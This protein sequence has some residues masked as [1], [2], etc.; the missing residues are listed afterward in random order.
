[1]AYARWRHILME[2]Q[3]HALKA[4]DEWNCTTGNY[5]DFLTH[6]HKAWHYLLHAEFHKA[7]IDYHYS[8][9]KT[10]HHQLIDGEPKAWDLDRCLRERF[11]DNKDPVRLNGELFVAL[12]NKV[13]H[14]YEHNLKIVTGGRAQALVVNYEQEMVAHFGPECSLADRLRFPISL[15][16]LTAEGREQ[17][18]AAAKKLPKHTRDLVAKFEA[19]IDPA[20]L[21]DLR[22]DYR[23]RLVPIIGSKTDADLAINFVKLDE[24]SES[25]RRTMVE[26]GRLGTVIE[27][28]KHVEVADK[29]KLLPGRVARLVE[30]QVP[31]EFSVHNEHAKMWRRLGVRPATG[32]SDPHATNAK[33]CIYSEAFGAYVYTRAWVKKVVREIGTVEKYRSFFGREPRMKTVTPFPKQFG[34]SEASD[35][36]QHSKSA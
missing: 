36:Q 18:Q 29:D 34:A 26:A 28:V 31:F 15:Q 19:A 8:D 16:A 6:M 14:R 3:R 12:R 10:G 17:L 24:L 32:A 23:V 30:D 21:D 27:K 4:V 2:S 33:Y 25:E 20:L 7:K 13:E 9:P 11:P 1:M 5:S 22:Y 35:A